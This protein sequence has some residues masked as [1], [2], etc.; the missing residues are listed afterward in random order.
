MWAS[1]ALV[2]LRA[3]RDGDVSWS[4]SCSTPNGSSTFTRM[5]KALCRH[6]VPTH[7]L[8]ERRRIAVHQYRHDRR[9]D[10]QRHVREPARK[11]VQPIRRGAAR[12]FGKNNHRVARCKL[13]RAGFD[14]APRDRRCSHIPPSAR[15]PRNMGC[16]SAR[17]SPRNTRAASATTTPLRPD[18]SGDSPPRLPAP[19]AQSLYTRHFERHD[20]DVL[21]HSDQRT[22]KP[23]NHGRHRTLTR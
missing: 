23:V 19:G 7:L 3:A 15:S 6:V 8:G 13:P 9:A 14:E 22:E 18:T 16:P 11:C 4:A 5:R 2:T 12:A 1:M 10:L 21:Q 20:A 17:F